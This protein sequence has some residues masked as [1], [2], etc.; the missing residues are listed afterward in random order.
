M[1]K[2]KDE[3]TAREYLDHRESSLGGY[4]TFITLFYPRDSKEEP[5][6]VLVYVAL[7][8]N[9][10][11]LGVSLNSQIAA[12]IATSEGNCGHNVEYLAKLCAF[13]RLN[14]PEYWDEHLA[15]LD[16]LTQKFLKKNNPTLLYHFEEAYLEESLFESSLT[17]ST[18]SSS[19]ASPD[20]ESSS[21]GIDE[22][23]GA[24]AMATNAMEAM[25][26]Q[27]ITSESSAHQV[28]SNSSLIWFLQGNSAALTFES[29]VAWLAYYENRSSIL[30]VNGD[31][32]STAYTLR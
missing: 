15:D 18:V 13:M 14:V 12:D 17:F 32:L 24:I 11:F 3:K 30:Q 29:I 21:S 23:L 26:L 1:F 28:L 10:L 31:M 2:I 22:S 19:D 16:K 7:P 20:M 6:P 25:N 9:P 4:S 5:I 8:S 27:D